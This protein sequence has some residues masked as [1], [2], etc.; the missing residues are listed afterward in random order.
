MDCNWYYSSQAS[1]DP[2]VTW[3][4]D[5]LLLSNRAT[6]S[7]KDGTS[8]LLIKAAEM[9]DSGIYTI[10][11]KNGSGKRET[12][13]FQV[14]VTGKSLACVFKYK[15]ICVCTDLQSVVN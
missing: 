6:I 11:L 3:L 13:S 14:Q 2:E 9:T 12:F 1:P 4:K 7:T 10:E 5:G 15:Y 8:Q